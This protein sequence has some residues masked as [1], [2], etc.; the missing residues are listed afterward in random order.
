[1]NRRNLLILVMAAAFLLTLPLAATADTIDVHSYS[2]GYKVLIKI[3]GLDSMWV[4]TAEFS[5][6]WGTWDHVYGYCVDPWQNVG[7]GS[8]TGYDIYTPSQADDYAANIYTEEGGLAAAFLMAN[9]STSLQGTGTTSMLDRTALQV[10]IWEVIHDY[11]S[12]DS[13]SLNLWDGLFKFYGSSNSS[14]STT[15]DY[16]YTQLVRNRANTMLATLPM[17]TGF[18][19][20]QIASLDAYFRVG[21]SGKEQDL[22]FGTPGGGETPEP[23]TM[24]L[25]GSA[26]AVGGYWRRRRSSKKVKAAA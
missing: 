16:N 9:F 12:S 19:A 23:G 20:E 24:L 11:D 6:S 13:A 22:L 21:V 15:W 7:T 25:L 26:M 1:M 2:M 3:D 17:G 5:L 10:A 14:S 4:P 8:H 18:T